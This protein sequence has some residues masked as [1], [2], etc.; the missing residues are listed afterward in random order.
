[1]I[2]KGEAELSN[3][4]TIIRHRQ[5]IGVRLCSMLSLKRGYV[6]ACLPL[7]NVHVCVVSCLLGKP[8]FMSLIHALS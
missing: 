5:T 6:Y 1:M 2:A 8:D 7:G 3:I 4:T